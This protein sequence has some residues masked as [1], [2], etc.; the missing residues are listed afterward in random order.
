[1]GGGFLHDV[2]KFHVFLKV[3]KSKIKKIKFVAISI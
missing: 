2:L 3:K 1:M